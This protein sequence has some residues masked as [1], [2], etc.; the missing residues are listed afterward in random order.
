MKSGFY[1]IHIDRAYF[2]FS[3]SVKNGFLVYASLH[4]RMP[5]N[6]YCHSVLYAERIA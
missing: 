3:L 6:L 2:Y 4:D 1:R 5:S